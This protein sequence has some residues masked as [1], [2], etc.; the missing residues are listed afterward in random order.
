LSSKIL[1]QYASLDPETKKRDLNAWRPVVI[2]VINAL[3]EMND[4]L[5]KLNLPIFYKSIVKLIGTEIPVELRMSLFGF[6]TRVGKSF[7]LLTDEDL[8]VSKPDIGG[9]NG[10]INGM[11]NAIDGNNSLGLKEYSPTN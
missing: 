11:S 7:A 8:I 2:T 10:E 6:F 5:F 3:I 4:E 1:E 9:E